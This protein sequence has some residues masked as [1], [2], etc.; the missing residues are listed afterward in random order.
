MITR[1][2]RQLGQPSSYGLESAS[3]TTVDRVFSLDW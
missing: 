3:D 1:Y 2:H